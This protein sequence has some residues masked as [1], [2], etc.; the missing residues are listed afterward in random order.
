LAKSVRFLLEVVVLHLVEGCCWAEQQ[1]GQ[2][3][4]IT[5]KAAVAPHAGW[6]AFSWM[7]LNVF[8]GW[9]KPSGPTATAWYNA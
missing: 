3:P 2:Q 1:Q 6:S 7:L 4:L 5:S 9:V 8:P